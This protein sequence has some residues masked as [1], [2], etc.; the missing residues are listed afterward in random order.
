M[1]LKLRTETGVQA[2][3]NYDAIP[4]GYYQVVTEQGNPIRRAWHL[5]K[6][7]RVLDCLPDLPGQSL[8]DVGCFA[9]TFLSGV[10]RERFSRQL[11]VDI[12]ERQIGYANRRFHTDF[13]E[14]RY[15]PHVAAL[16]EVDETFD[17]V[18][19][20]EV[21]EHLPP[22]EVP[23]MMEAV[24]ARL[25]PGGKLVISTPNYTSAWP[26]LEILINRL[27]DL[28]Y[29]EQHLC[30][31][32]YFNVISKLGRLW[33]GLSSEL[34]LDYRTTTHFISPFLAAASFRFAR[35]VARLYPHQSWHFPLGS[36]LLLVFT[37]QTGEKC[38]LEGRPA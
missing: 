24:T 38:G 22:A 23:R 18:T 4:E 26:L 14:F 33:P 36:L 6:F 20:I 32:N 19:L 17:C 30:K 28:S 13:R 35:G 2:P 37:R 34:S 5:H 8:L 27:S 12:V 31:F 16:N 15:I 11:G 10:P 29:E 7:E 21:I 9:G 25:K 3:F 1:W